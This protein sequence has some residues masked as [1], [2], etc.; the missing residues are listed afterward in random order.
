ML[1]KALDFEYDGQLLSDYGFIIC[2]FDYGS[3]ATEVSSGATITFSKKSHNGGLIR[4]IQFCMR[5]D[6]QVF[7]SAFL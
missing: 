1:M 6:K 5:A 4:Q 2:N 7:V 3:G